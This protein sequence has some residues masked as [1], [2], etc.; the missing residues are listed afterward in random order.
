MHPKE[1]RHIAKIDY[2]KTVRGNIM[3]GENCR[4]ANFG[5]AQTKPVIEVCMREIDRS[6][7]P[8]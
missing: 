2:P 8:E 1:H 7:S 3:T 4:L 5:T 6:V